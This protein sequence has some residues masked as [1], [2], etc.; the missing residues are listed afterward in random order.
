[1]LEGVAIELCVVVE[2][3][4]VR[5][6]VLSRAEDITAADIRTRQTYLLWTGDLKAVLRLAVEC[7]A[8]FVAQVGIGVLVADD[9]HRIGHA[10]SAMV[11]GEYDF[12]A[13]G[14]NTAEHLGCR[15][16]A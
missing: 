11:G 7:F 13:Q 6:E 1:M 3:V 15:R 4:G 14:S 2:V 5:K 8:D 10:R 9:L 16:V 12:V